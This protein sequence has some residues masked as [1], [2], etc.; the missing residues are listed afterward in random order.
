MMHAHEE[1]GPLCN[2]MQGGMHG[3]MKAEA[4]GR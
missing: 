3:G 2:K 4:A 1:E